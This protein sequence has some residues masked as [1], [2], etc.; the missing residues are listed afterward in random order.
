MDPTI[1][2]LISVLRGEIFGIDGGRGSAW[3]GVLP[4]IWPG[5]HD[6]L[7]PFFPASNVTYS[8]YIQAL[9]ETWHGKESTR[10]KSNKMVIDLYVVSSMTWA[11]EYQPLAVTGTTNANKP[12]E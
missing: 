8:P 5:F 1:I 9:R 11:E 2:D 12:M 6:D 7:P 10:L 3:E 4:E